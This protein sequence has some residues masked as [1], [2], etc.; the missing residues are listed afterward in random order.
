LQKKQSNNLII[1]INN[2]YLAKENANISILSHPILD[3]LL[4]LSFLISEL[5]A[6]HNA[7]VQK[8][9]KTILK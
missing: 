2:V 9:L 1:A 3:I 8:L 4:G 7:R 5:C 6:M